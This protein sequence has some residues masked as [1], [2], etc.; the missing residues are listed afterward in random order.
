M[1]DYIA[2]PVQAQLLYSVID[3]V[4][5]RFHAPVARNDEK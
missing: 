5:A 3:R 2:K 1:D 4:V